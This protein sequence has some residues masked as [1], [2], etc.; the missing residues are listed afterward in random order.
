MKSPRRSAKIL[1]VAA[2]LLLFVYFGGSALAY[3]NATVGRF[4][5]VYISDWLPAYDL[6]EGP[7]ETVHR[8]RQYRAAVAYI[9][10]RSAASPKTLEFCPYSEAEF[11]WYKATKEEA[12]SGWVDAQNAFGATI[13]HHVV[14]LFYPYQPL[15][16]DVV[17]MDGQ[18]W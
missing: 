17:V 6:I 10:K 11:G 16:V 2:I 7:K 8:Y 5:G 15:V 14:V 13:R 12:M 4:W 9:T 1:A 3:R 18:R